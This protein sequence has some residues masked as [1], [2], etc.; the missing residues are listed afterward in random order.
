M[1]GWCP[2]TN[3]EH[4]LCCIIVFSPYFE[5]VTF[6]CYVWIVWLMSLVLCIVMRTSQGCLSRSCS[7]I[8][9]HHA[10]VFSLL[11]T[12]GISLTLLHDA[13]IFSIC[14]FGV[15]E[16]STGAVWSTSGV[17]NK[18]TRTFSWRCSGVF[19]GSAWWFSCLAL[20]FGCLPWQVLV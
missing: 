20:V 9:S 17:G 3:Y 10:V 7:R 19:I 14:L 6:I 2:V 15:G 18:T 8:P 11:T 16:W 13:N 4:L 1:G 12:L 5:H